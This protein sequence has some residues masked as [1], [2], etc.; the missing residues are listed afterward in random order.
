MYNELQIYIVFRWSIR[1]PVPSLGD[2]NSTQDE[3]DRFYSFWF[4]W[5]SW[6]EFSYLDEEN[7]EKGEDR[8][9]RR[10]IEKINKVNIYFIFFYFSRSVGI[11]EGMILR[12]GNSFGCN[13]IY[14]WCKYTIRYHR[15]R[16]TFRLVLTYSKFPFTFLLPS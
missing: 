3:V 8:W 4:N 15:Y 1:H 13:H 5:D 16:S 9:E 12:L 11:V 6:R 2:I 7:K 10:E 14:I